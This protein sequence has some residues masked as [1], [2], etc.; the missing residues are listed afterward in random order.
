VGV[1]P[2]D[3][4]LNPLSSWAD[5]PIY[6]GYRVYLAF[7]QGVYGD[8]DG[9]LGERYKFSYDAQTTKVNIGG[10]PPVD[11]TRIANIPAIV[12]D[13]PG[14][15]PLGTVTGDISTR[16]MFTGTKTYVDYFSGALPVYIISDNKRTAMTLA[17]LT[18]QMTWT[19]RESLIGNGRFHSIGRAQIGPPSPVG[20]LVT[21]TPGG[22]LISVPLIVP[23]LF[24]YKS[25]VTP[26]NAPKLARVEFAIRPTGPAS[27]APV[28]PTG[29]TVEQWI[30]TYNRDH[31]FVTPTDP[32]AIPALPTEVPAVRESGQEVVVD[33]D[34]ID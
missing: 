1:R 2:L 34:L 14:I 27:R 11:A 24:V 6:H 30:A 17:W 4:E 12:V 18:H 13:L 33:V 5:E 16:D 26:I 19:L 21:G 9:T 10:P 7:L 28:M 15:N 32:L 8:L 25:S 31:G 20:Q 23:F 3:D 29:W 22:P